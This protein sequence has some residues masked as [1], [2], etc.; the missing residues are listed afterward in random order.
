MR[1]IV[2][3]RLLIALAVGAGIVVA[4]GWL[5]TAGEIVR[6]GM[7]PDVGAVRPLADAASTIRERE[8]QLDRTELEPPPPRSP[9]RPAN[10][11]HTCGGHLYDSQGRRAR[12]TGVNWFGMETGTFAPHG[13]WTRNWQSLLDQIAQLGYNAIRLPYTNEM[14]RPGAEVG[15]VNYVVNPDLER[16]TPVEVLD[17]LVEGARTRGLKVVLDRHRPDSAGQSDLWYTR[18][19]SEAQWIADWQFLAARY[20]GNDA[21]VGVDLHNEPKGAATWGSG[22]A[23]TD[24]RLAAERAGNAVLAANPY[25]LVFVQGVERHQNEWYWWGGNLRGAAA[26]RVRLA[27]PNRLVYSPHDYGPGVYQQGWFLAADFPNNLPG[28]WD[29]N[30]GYLVRRSIA[31]VVVGEFGGR[32][33]GDD[34]EGVWQQ[35]LLRYL[36]EREV[37]FFAWSLNPNSID[38]GGVLDEDWQRVVLAKENAYRPHLAA[39]IDEPIVRPAG[40]WRLSQRSNDPSART[41]NIGFS[42]SATNDG[43]AAVEP[44]RL[45]VRYWFSSGDLHGSRQVVEIDWAALGKEHVRAEVVDA[46]QGGQT[47]YIRF[48]FSR[49]AP[50]IAPYQTTGEV[51]VRLHKEDWSAYDQTNDFSFRPGSGFEEWDGMALYLDGRRVWGREP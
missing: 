34:A 45:E 6:P 51:R 8:C 20:R 1:R 49:E 48:T 17:R 33:T 16:L 22:E 43:S 46:P 42:F 40:G 3:K 10:Y 35:S 5:A 30:W 27:L 9:G 23:A 12:L 32:S 13:L 7:L 39:R 28:V 37:G 26:D 24:W 11:L 21:V 44:A 36:T 19:V 4:A 14:L 50:P 47:G 2:L 25:L 38:T 18:S 29:T 15:G 41:S 31:P